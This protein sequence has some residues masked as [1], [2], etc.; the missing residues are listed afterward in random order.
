LKLPFA[1]LLA[2]IS[3]EALGLMRIG[4]GGVFFA[5]MLEMI[6]DARA[7]YSD[8]GFITRAAMLGNV[9]DTRITLLDMVT[10]PTAATTFFVVAAVVA[11]LFMIGWRTR[12]M[13]VL[14]FVIAASLH[15][16][17]I[18]ITDGHDTVVRVIFGV[19]CF[20]PLGARYSIDA[21]LRRAR[22]QEQEEIRWTFPVRLLQFQFAWI[23]FAAALVKST[24]EP[25]RKGEAVRSALSLVHGMARPIAVHFVNLRP[26]TLGMTWST[27]AFEGGFLFLVFSPF[28]TKYARRLAILSGVA[29]HMGIFALMNV[30]WFPQ[31]MIALYAMY[32]DDEWARVPARLW[33]N[34]V[35]KRPALVTSLEWA[36]R[37]LAE[38]SANAP[39]I[40]D[41]IARRIAPVGRLA[42]MVALVVV[43]GGGM[44]TT[45][46]ETY[47]P[48]SSW[49]TPPSRLRDV[50]DTGEVWQNWDMFAPNPTPRDTW[51]NGKGKL[52]DGTEVDVLGGRTRPVVPRPGFFYS[53]W[54]KIRD[55]Y[56]YYT[57]DYLN[58]FGKYVCR[59]WN[60]EGVTRDRQLVTFT[61]ERVTQ[62][63][64]PSDGEQAPPES[65]EIW[66]HHCF[67]EPAPA[68]VSA[69]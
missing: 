68:A 50:I 63:L 56:V 65:V 44:W 42:L 20:I 41:P 7:F 54:T 51:M 24:G 4:F 27:L 46:P 61:L 6:P 29:F 59:E 55:N 32:L 57:D 67:D 10:S 16:R 9:R 49:A 11:F 36:K 33:A 66:N 47:L 15:D 45:I 5:S 30:G 37:W 38:S 60:S 35:A 14:A 43:Y 1:G 18:E 34:G 3:P 64:P 2:P 13:T 19:L 69:L 62:D 21:A 58:P 8:E 17:N 25:W 23:Y 40:D 48:K 26:F 28:F 22:G 53:R 12:L 31:T 39:V 52:R